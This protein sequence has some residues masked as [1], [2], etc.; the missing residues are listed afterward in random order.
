LDDEELKRIRE[1]YLELAGK[2]REGLKR[3]K[4]DTGVPGV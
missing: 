2:A 1:D 4:A 3:G